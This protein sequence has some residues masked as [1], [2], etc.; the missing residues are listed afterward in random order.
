MSRAEFIQNRGA[1]EHFLA[2]RL[3]GVMALLAVGMFACIALRDR[4][5]SAG[6]ELPWWINP[7]AL[8]PMFAFMVFAVARLD[9]VRRRRF[10]LNC[11]QCGKD[12]S[13]V[14]PTLVTTGRCG[15]CGAT[16]LDPEPQ[17]AAS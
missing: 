11:G 9:Q 8:V 10:R 14:A 6:T 1:A 13:T 4:W 12:L 15:H 16:V 3:A 17:P 2:V 5:A 7:V